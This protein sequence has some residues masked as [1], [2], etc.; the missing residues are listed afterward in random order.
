MKWTMPAL[1][2]GMTV[3]F[4][5][6]LISVYLYIRFREKFLG[7]WAIA[8]I[9]HI[10]RAML[11]VWSIK[12]ERPEFLLVLDHVGALGSGLPLIL[13]TFSFL[14]TR[15]PPILVAGFIASFAWYLLAQ[16]FS[17]HFLLQSTPIWLFLGI[18]HIWIGLALIRLKGL[19]QIAY[20][21]AGWAFVLWGI[22]KAGYP[23]LR[24]SSKFGPWGY[25]TGGL[26]FLILAASLLMIYVE[27][28]KG[29]LLASEQKY[30]SLVGNIPDAVWTADRTG[31]IM[32]NSKEIPQ[33]SDAQFQGTKSR[34]KKHKFSGIHPDDRERVAAAWMNFIDNKHLLDVEYRIAI[35]DGQWAWLRDKAVAYRKNGDIYADGITSDITSSKR[36][37]K[38]KEILIEQLNAKIDQVRVLTG[39]LPICSN[40]KKIRDDQGYWNQIEGYI[41]EHSDAKFS[42]G[43]CPDCASILY[44]ELHKKINE[45]H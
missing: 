6:T 24:T 36:A 3:P 20:P 43:L 10:V 22:Q 30:R 13:G 40:C 7:L 19:K 25:F 39:L 27:E 2:Y 34:C 38:E 26:L 32:Y 17:L 16:I 33:A 45:T 12:V 41:Q 21:I 35:S 1:M 29:K 28:I 23:L 42:H 11:M 5:L 8:W 18:A 9:V 15:T 4:F 37:E 44:P 31:C 14:K